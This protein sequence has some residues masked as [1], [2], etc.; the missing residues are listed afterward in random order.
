MAAVK[1][2]AAS[3][4][5]AVRRRVGEGDRRVAR[6]FGQVLRELRDARCLSQ[7]ALGD[8]AGCSK[9]NISL[10]ELGK[11]NPSLLLLFDLAKALEISPEELVS[12]T[13]ARVEEQGREPPG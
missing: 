8:R 5:A 2:G 12:S 3:G 1:L 13:N 6:A 11:Q 7:E 9:N 10:L 4:G